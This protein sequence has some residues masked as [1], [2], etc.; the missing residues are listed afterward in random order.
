MIWL[1]KNSFTSKDFYSLMYNKSV[2][3]YNYYITH[4]R[5]AVE[6]RQLHFLV[7]TN[8]ELAALTLLWLIKIWD[9]L[10]C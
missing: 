3:A 5:Y 6:A 2:P 1:T 4:V 8:A 7:N 10:N 9:M